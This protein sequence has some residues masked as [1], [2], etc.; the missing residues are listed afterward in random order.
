V[1][2]I[3]KFHVVSIALITTG[4]QP[5]NGTTGY[6]ST[7]KT[8][9]RGSLQF[10]YT[11]PK[12]AFGSIHSFDHGYYSLKKQVISRRPWTYYINHEMKVCLISTSAALFWHH[13]QIHVQFHI[14]NAPLPGAYCRIYQKQYLGKSKRKRLIKLHLC[15]LN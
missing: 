6:L 15:S 14:S 2:K 5:C 11:H 13:Y 10:N 7:R 12:Y 9:T 4:R 1:H 8:Y 3:K